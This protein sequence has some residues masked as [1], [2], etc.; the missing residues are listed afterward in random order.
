MPWKGEHRSRAGSHK[1]PDDDVFEYRFGRDPLV[2][3]GVEEV[4]SGSKL[5]IEKRES[6]EVTS[7]VEV[8]Y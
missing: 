6:K 5:S 7:R 1:W 2:L 4:R 8:E 3:P